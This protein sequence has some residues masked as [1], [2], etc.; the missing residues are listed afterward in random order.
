[1]DIISL[2]RW[3][4]FLTQDGTLSSSIPQWSPLLFRI[5]IFPFPHIYS[6]MS[7]SASY[8]T[9]PSASPLIPPPFSS[10]RPPL[11]PPYTA[12]ILPPLLALMLP[13]LVMPW[14]R[15][16]PSH[17]CILQLCTT[18]AGND[19]SGGEDHILHIHDVYRL[20]YAP[21]TLP[22]PPKRLQ[23]SCP[24]NISSYCSSSP[25]ADWVKRLPK[26][27]RSTISGF[28]DF[29]DIGMRLSA[30][31]DY[32]RRNALIKM[33][34]TVCWNVGAVFINVSINAWKVSTCANAKL[35]MTSHKCSHADTPALWKSVE[36]KGGALLGLLN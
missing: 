18:F 1:M 16:V 21:S 22:N 33:P 7:S 29:A 26:E 25:S 35:S 23:T 15:K 14:L 36:L 32:T 3:N 31:S 9:S 4:P 28:S 8:F 10:P 13:S 27:L 24:A 30:L 6:S 19:D 20:A 2:E 5:A 12:S 11:R 34:G 17:F